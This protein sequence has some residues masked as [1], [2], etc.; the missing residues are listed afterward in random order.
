[1]TIPG[2]NEWLL[3]IIKGAQDDCEENLK[4]NVKD[5]IAAEMREKISR[6]QTYQF[7][8]S[9]TKFKNLGEEQLAFAKKYAFNNELF[10]KLPKVVSNASRYGIAGILN[11]VGKESIIT[12]NVFLLQEP[13]TLNE[14]ILEVWMSVDY[15]DL[16]K[17]QEEDMKTMRLWFDSKRG[18]YVLDHVLVSKDK[19]G[20]FWDFENGKVI[21]RKLPNGEVEQMRYVYENIDYCPLEI[22]ENNESATADWEFAE[23]SIRLFAKFNAVIE[24]EW[25]FIKVQMVQNL[26]YNPEK[27]ASEV[28]ADIESGK[29]RVH[30][31]AD[32][33]GKLQTALSYLSNGGVTADIARIIKENFKEE[34]KEL[35]FAFG[36]LGGANNKHGTEVI[37]ANLDAWNYLSF[38]R[39]YY[40]AFL[41]KLWYK[42]FD[43]SSAFD[44]KL[45]T[46]EIVEI[47]VEFSDAIKMLF[48]INSPQQK[49]PAPKAPT[50][51]KKD[52]EESK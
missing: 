32:P 48:E 40:Q 12:Q 19:D 28:Q 14:V 47:D 51:E 3:K 35:T 8:Y 44:K 31:I 39:T 17:Y 16:D 26:V 18:K 43:M 25:E 20:E 4:S 29:T 38:R 23:E 41:E 24:R 45:A 22:L 13:K 9:K 1:M 34:I 10:K 36:S 46:E 7:N 37:S 42:I 2:T 50:P 49:Q 21:E 6:Q 15:I 52:E 11:R 33:D 5:L 30:E 27:T